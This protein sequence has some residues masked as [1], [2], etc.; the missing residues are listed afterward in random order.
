MATSATAASKGQ[1]TIPPGKNRKNR[2]D[3][4]AASQ[5]QSPAVFFE[6]RIYRGASNEASNN[7]VSESKS[8]A[9]K[10][11]ATK[12]HPPNAPVTVTVSVSVTLPSAVRSCWPD[13]FPTMSSAKKSIRKGIFFVR[14]KT[15]T[16]GK[17][18]T[19]VAVGDTIVRKL[20]NQESRFR[21]RGPSTEEIIARALGGKLR[22]AYLD[23]H[24]AVVIKPH[25]MPVHKVHGNEVRDDDDDEDGGDGGDGDAIVDKTS[26]N[27]KQKSKVVSMH[28]L[29]LH[30]L[31]SPKNGVDVLRRPAAIH[32]LDLPTYGLLVIARTRPSARFLSKAFEERSLYKRYRALVHGHVHGDINDKAPTKGTG[33][34]VKLPIGGKE[35]ISEYFIVQKLVVDG[36]GVLTVP[37]EKPTTTQPMFL[38]LVDLVL[39]TGRKH[40]LRKHMASLGHPIVGDTRYGKANDD[41]DLSKALV[42]SSSTPSTP[43]NAAN[44]DQK[45][46]AKPTPWTLSLSLAA[47]EISFPHPRGAIPTD[48]GKDGP[49]KNTK[50]TANNDDDDVD[51]EKAKNT[52]YSVVANDAKHSFDAIKGTLNVAIDMPKSMNNI[53]RTSKTVPSRRQGKEEQVEPREVDFE[54]FF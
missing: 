29:L 42:A 21:T 4:N 12:A 18:D 16:K 26:E 11:A 28:E 6:E 20:P 50:S 2:K 10:R 48:T 24:V 13:L 7:V 22:I 5:R 14:K 31:P 37:Q 36:G 49:D 51:D 44:K 43:T 23:E 34:L 39:H 33:T 27:A 45:P 9:Q 41:Q 25:G 3:G 40:Q 8:Q 53:L 46:S 47:V 35:C 1:K 52:K 17:C 38:T 19:Q 15:T 32:R 54:F 30:C